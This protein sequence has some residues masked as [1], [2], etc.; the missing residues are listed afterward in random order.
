V[1]TFA[2][3]NVTYSDGQVNVMPLPEAIMANGFIPETR[4]A[5]GMPLAAQHLNWLFRD[6][7]RKSNEI[8]Q[9][10][11][12]LKNN[13]LPA[14]VPIACPL[15]TAPEGY[16]KCNGAA[17]DVDKYP[18]LAEGYPSGVLPDLRGEFIRGW[19]DG[20]GVDTGRKILSA[21]QSQNLE[22]DHYTVVHRSGTGLSSPVTANGTR[23]I[24]T[25][26]GSNPL[27]VKTGL[28]GADEAR[29]RNVA[30]LYIVRAA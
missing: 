22:H 11:E 1:T 29:P 8:S 17:F 26:N 13:I 19:D 16:L 21:Q 6:L 18:E 14:W 20:R 12:Q 25:N 5:P 24:H 27:D 7:Y 9:A 3:K 15:E 10:A 4:D 28:A 2:E 23:A 30:F